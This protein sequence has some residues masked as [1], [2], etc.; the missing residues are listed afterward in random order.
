MF[1][2]GQSH[3]KLALRGVRVQIRVGVFAQEKIAPQAVEVDVELCRRHD[4]YRGEGLDACLNY[5]PVYRYLTEE[6]PKRGHVE[7]LEAWAEDL[8]G[9]CLNDEKVDACLVRIR[10]PDIFPESIV[11]E[12]E[13][14]RYRDSNEQ[15]VR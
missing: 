11:P 5:E 3:Q 14:L 6:W 15:P 1:G 9:Y 10:K 12:I 8:V 13:V 7:L 4:A 2:L